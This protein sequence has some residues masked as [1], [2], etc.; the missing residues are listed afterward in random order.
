MFENRLDN[1]QAKFI[2]VE[3][4]QRNNFREKRGFSQN[5]TWIWAKARLILSLTVD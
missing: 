1:N 2:A 4:S 5:I 3:F